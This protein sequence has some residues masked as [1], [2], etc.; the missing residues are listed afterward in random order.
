MGD[1]DAVPD[2]VLADTVRGSSEPDRFWTL[3]NTGEVTPGILSPLDWS[4]WDNFE[5]AVRQAWCDLGIMARSEVFLPTDPNIRQTATFY[6]RHALNV[7]Y[8][9][10]RMGSIPGASPDDFE[11]DTCGS[12]RTGL[13]TEKQS[14]RRLPFM[15]AKLPGAYRRLDS[16][17]RALHVETKSW[18]TREVLH[19]RAAGDPVAD[20]RAAGDRF[21]A[22]M[23]LHIRVRTFI[24]AVQGAL[25]DLAASAGHPELALPL[26]AGYGDVTELSLAR[27]MRRLGLGEIT[28]ADFVADYGYYGPN[29]GMVWTTPWRENPDALLPRARALAAREDPEARERAAVAARV[30]AERQILA[31]IGAAR[32][33]LARILFRQAARQVRNLELGKSTYHMAI[34]GCRAAARRAGA[35]LAADGVVD[36]PEDVFFFTLSELEQRPPARA[37]EIVE[38]RRACRKEYEAIELPMTFTGMPEPLLVPADAE[39]V[40]EI[41]GIPGSAGV[42]EGRVRVVHDADE[43]D[44]LLEPG[45]ILVCRVTNPSWTPLFA[46]VDGI[47]IDIGGPNSHGPIIAR[48]LGV[49]C[50]INV[51]T[52]TTAL[53]DGDLVRVDGSA[54]RVTLLSRA[55][56]PVQPATSV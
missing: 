14:N 9:R 37:R 42:V 33:P 30:D 50:V 27:D 49:P 43:G 41:V 40:D 39:D 2:P 47:V 21:R 11:R 52:G 4:V 1:L 8:V 48:E 19:G 46:L 20:L 55:G 45:E 25:V 54:G 15:L 5:L 34:D 16:E 38:Y 51:G 24:T 7:D 53:R 26:F 28:P 6:G 22:T 56:R 32:R 3:A 12:V 36:D 35:R 31:A 29:E 23:R 13:A 10:R 17:L 44:D 18:W